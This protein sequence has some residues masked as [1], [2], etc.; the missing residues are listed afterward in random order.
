[1]NILGVLYRGKVWQLNVANLSRHSSLYYKLPAALYHSK[2]C[3][4][5]VENAFGRNKQTQ[6]STH[7]ITS[8]NVSVN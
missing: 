1:M 8:H 4:Y 7:N 6:V 3:Q 2:E 5:L